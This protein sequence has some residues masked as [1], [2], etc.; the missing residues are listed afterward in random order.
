MEFITG[1]HTDIGAVRE[2]NQDAT[3]IMQA[4][5]EKGNICMVIVCDGMGGLSKGELASATIIKA[6]ER[7]FEEKLPELIETSSLEKIRTLWEREL[8]FWSDRLKEYGTRE[9]I[10]LGTTFSGMLFVDN[11][12]FWVHVGDSR[13]YKLTDFSIEQIT[14]DHTVVAR[15]LAKGTMTLEEAEHSNMRNKLTQCVGASKVL[16]PQSGMGYVEAGT[17]FL[18]CS[19]GFYHKNFEDEMMKIQDKGYQTENDLDHFCQL[20]IERAVQRGEKDNLSAIALKCV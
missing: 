15:E 14:E 3:C 7:G 11:Q 18:L 6:F 9:N 12:Y 10:L 1:S 5:T 19:D 20:A 4:E 2:V 16:E 17:S 8:H 13:I